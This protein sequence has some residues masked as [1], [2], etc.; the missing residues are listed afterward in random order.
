MHTLFGA[1]DC[2]SMVF[3]P[4]LKRLSTSGMIDL[5]CHLLP[6]IDDGSKDLEMSLEMARI[7]IADGIETTACTPHIYPGLYENDG[8]GI[9]RQVAK[10]AEQFAEREIPLS[11]TFGADIQ[12]VPELLSGLTSG[13]MP[14]INGSRYFLFEP[15]HHTVPVRF[16]ELLFD[17]LTAGYVPVITH[18]ERLTWLDEEHYPWFTDAA[19]SGAWIQLTS[20]AVIGRFGK[21][22]KYWSERFLGDGMVHL[23]A[24]DAHEPQHRPPILSEGRQAAEQW[25]DPEEVERL[26]LQRPQAILDNTEPANIPLPP[27]LTGEMPK[28]RQ[29]AEKKGFFGKLFR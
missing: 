15:P 28:R 10:L 23:L 13:S 9:R 21:R 27:G 3:L 17:T 19:R 6:G 20:G 5:H 4:V 14:T 26:V 22:A 18:P 1:H 29:Q 7:A 12:M 8:A 11:L 16:T 25:L 2:G 24:T